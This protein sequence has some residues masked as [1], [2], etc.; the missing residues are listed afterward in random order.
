MSGGE[1]TRAGRSQGRLIVG[2]VAI[3]CLSIGIAIGVLVQGTAGARSEDKRLNIRSSS[4]QPDQLSSAFARVAGIVEPRVVNITVRETA[5]RAVFAREGTGSGV[6]VN[7]SGFIITNHH[8]VRR[9]AKITVK[10][11][12]G[13]EYDARIIGLDD[14]TDLAVLKIEAG[15]S[16]PAVPM[17]TVV[18]PA[19]TRSRASAQVSS[20][21][22][23]VSG[24]L[25]AGPVGGASAG[26]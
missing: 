11:A 2:L 10:L 19:L 4:L 25:P 21:R 8:V 14:Q 15:Q 1:D 5:E 26:R 6:I 22:N 17:M 24:G 20:S 16:V 9:A 7:S 12:S 13:K 3:S 18:V 23:T